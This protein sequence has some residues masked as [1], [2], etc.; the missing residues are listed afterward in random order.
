M[1]KTKSQKIE[2][3]LEEIKELLKEIS[4]KL[5][6]LKPNTIHYYYYFGDKKKD[7]YS[8]YS[9]SSSMTSN[10]VWYKISRD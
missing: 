3:Q 7:W 4:R 6:E 9:I 10:L 2:K 1:R 8:D 5:D